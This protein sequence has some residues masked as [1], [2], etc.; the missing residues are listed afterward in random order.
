MVPRKVSSCIAARYYWRPEVYLTGA[1][2]VA[3]AKFWKCIKAKVNFNKIVS[4][5]RPSAYCA[6]DYINTRN[7]SL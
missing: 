2:G 3:T 7:L 5:E 4:V 1:T 6:K